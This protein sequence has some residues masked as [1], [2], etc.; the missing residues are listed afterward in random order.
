MRK[1]KIVC[2]IGPASESEEM[3]EKLIKAGMNVAR[4]NFSHGDQAEHKA[5]IDTI[6]KVSKRLGKTVAILLD[7][8]GPEIRTHNMKDGLIELEKGSE[9]TV[10]M[11]EV[12]G[13]PEKFSVTY[14][15]LIN[16]VEEGS[17]ILLDDGLIELQVKSIDKAN[18]EVLCDVLNTG[19]LKNKKGV[20]L[21]GVKVSLP[22]ITDKDAD[23]INFGI[24]EGVDFIAASFVRRPS[25]VLD[26]R[27]LLEAKQNKNI[28]IIPKI[29]NQEGIDNIKEIL[30]VSDG[31]MVAR[32]DMG[33]EIPPE[34][35]PMVQ[36]DLIRQCNKLG[37]PVITATQM[38]DSM[39]RNPRATRAEA[40]DVAN[41]IY[42][43][44]DAVMLSGE[45]AAGQYPEEAVKT[46]RNIAVSAEAAQDYKKLLSDRTKL[47]ETSLVNA[48]GVSVAH[49]ALNLNVKAIVAATESG[50]TA[51]TISKYRP[52]SDIIAVTPN[53]ETA[54]QCALVWGIFPVVKEG[55]KTTDALLN[56]AVATAVET[57]RVQNGDLI[58]ITAG[59]P[60]GEKGTTNMM[61]L[62][63]VGDELAKG[64]GIGR[65]SV[66][67]KTLVVKDASELEGKDLSESIIVTSSVDETLVPYIEN[68]I[69]LITEENGITSP[70]AIIGLEKGIPTVVGVENATSEIQSDVLITV[71]ANQGKIFE[72]YANV[73]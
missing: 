45:T 47:V 63:L 61:K 44:T 18:G 26:I 73:L 22:G 1:T 46:M 17:Y 66:V 50:S 69:G 34:S 53:A 19:E 6:R 15:N 70:S 21:P 48:I 5:R 24:S 10:S 68:A 54:R 2:T 27:K 31:L 64:Q 32:G 23:D 38:L 37:K 9:V 28:S 11:T 39:Q 30:E 43:G 59:V 72:G 58:I 4:L 14:E 60:T 71:D 52:Q 3:L 33:V 65:S 25:D 35:V 8:K 40:S 55:R 62:H 56:N 29:E 7:T 57:E 16:D 12:E 67:G 51:R 42:D 13:T 20:N 41:A 36:K 49:T